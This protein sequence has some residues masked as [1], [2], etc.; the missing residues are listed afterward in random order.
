MNTLGKRLVWIIIAVGIALFCIALIKESPRFIQSKISSI[1]IGNDWKADFKDYIRISGNDFTC[2]PDDGQDWA[3][4][5]ML[6]GKLL[7]MT[8]SHTT[9]SLT[10]CTV[11]YAGISRACEFTLGYGWDASLTVNDSLGIS[12]A[13]MAELR[14]Q[15]PLLYID[16]FTWLSLGVV[17]A[18]VVVGLVMLLLLTAL[19]KKPSAI[20]SIWGF[21]IPVWAVCTAAIVVGV[22]VDRVSGVLFVLPLGVVGTLILSVI[23]VW[24]NRLDQKKGVLFAHP[25]KWAAVSLVVFWVVNLVTV[26]GL[27]TLGFVD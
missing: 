26:F 14:A 7:E 21:R 19:N 13:R 3:C 12:D 6:E 20:L 5:V 1:L 17:A 9:Q 15:K 23:I 22:L 25:L 16:E 24:L 4:Q 10:G 11:V 2:Q 8:V 27:L 18:A